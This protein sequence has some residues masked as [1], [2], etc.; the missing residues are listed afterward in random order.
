MFN[1]IT[2]ENVDFLI[3]EFH[4]SMLVKNARKFYIYNFDEKIAAQKVEK[5][6]TQETWFNVKFIYSLYE[7]SQ[8]LQISFVKTN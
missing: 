7:G 1:P 2:G 4:Q 6:T 8:Q 3:Q 5:F